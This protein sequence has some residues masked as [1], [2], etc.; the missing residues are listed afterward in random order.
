MKLAL[1]LLA[2]LAAGCSPPPPVSL[3]VQVSCAPEAT[4]LRQRCA[5][6]LTDRHTG[7]P[8]EGAT[9]TL[10]ADM[11]SM[12]LAH[13]AHPVAASPGPEAG[14][15]QGTLQLE[16]TGRW[17]ITARITGPVSDQVTHAIEIK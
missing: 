17:V 3:A 16:M 15:Y 9:V 7:R 10:S 1:L 6:R 14:A 2:V 5:V 11:P 8:V 4:A 13:G 12:P